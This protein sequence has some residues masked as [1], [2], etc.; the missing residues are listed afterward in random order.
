MIT[1]P[2]F[3]RRSSDPGTTGTGGD[4]TAMNAN[5]LRD[6]SPSAARPVRDEW[7]LYDPQQAGM[8]ALLRTI[9]DTPPPVSVTTISTSEGEPDADRVY[10]GMHEPP[11]QQTATDRSAPATATAPAKSQV[12]ALYTLEAPARCPECEQ[13]IRTLRVLRVLRT[14]VSFTSTLP[15]KGY[16]IVCPECERLLS[17]ELSG[18]V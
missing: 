11:V 8:Q 1:I 5:A 15:R 14:Q 4:N 13:E 10:G 7:G 12:G 6:T 3:R 9:D 16:V 17:A 18:L 2:G